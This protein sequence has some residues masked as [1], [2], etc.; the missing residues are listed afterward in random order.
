MRSSLDDPRS[1]V[2]R[3]VTPEGVIPEG[4]IPY[5]EDI[6]ANFYRNREALV[7]AVCRAMREAAKS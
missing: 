7:E 4:A 2:V 1:E 6:L 5:R 3:R